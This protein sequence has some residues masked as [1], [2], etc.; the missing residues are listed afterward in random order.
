M[1][2]YLGLLAGAHCSFLREDSGKDYR[3]SSVC[4]QTTDAMTISGIRFS[5]MHAWKNWN[6]W[7]GI[8]ERTNKRPKLALADWG[9]KVLHP[10]SVSDVLLPRALLDIQVDWRTVMRRRLNGLDF[11]PCSIVAF[12]LGV[13]RTSLASSNSVVEAQV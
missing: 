3:Q 11:T 2:R 4:E 13:I 9:L 5:H 12:L 1:I 6:R 10:A 7:T 8:R